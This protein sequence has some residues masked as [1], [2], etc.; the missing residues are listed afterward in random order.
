MQFITGVTAPTYRYHPAIIAQA[1]ASLDTL[2]PNRI[3]LGIGTGEAMNEVPLGYDWPSPKFRLKKTIDAIKVIRNLWKID[4]LGHKLKDK[5]EVNSTNYEQ[6]EYS[7]YY[8]FHSKSFTNNT[9]KQNQFLNYNGD[10]FHIRNAKLY[11]PPLTNIPIYMAGA[12]VQSIKAAAKYTEGLITVLSPEETRKKNIF[13]IFEDAVKK[14]GKNSN[15]MEKIVEYKISYSNDYDKAFQSATFWRSTLIENIFNQSIENPLK[16]QQKA[17]NDVSDEK[18]KN[19]I[20]ITTSLEDI[21]KSIEEYFKVGYTRV[22][23]HST[24][25]NEIEFVKE[26]GKKVLS[27]F[28]KI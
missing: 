25:P 14:E 21:I 20:Q 26:I 7:N 27:Y 3:G 24:S 11:T 6:N 12:G 1:F 17:I 13:Q 8:P 23:I 19:S 5:K 10:Y 18:I 4:E 15:Q 22:Y 9:K 28:T 2:F 16:L